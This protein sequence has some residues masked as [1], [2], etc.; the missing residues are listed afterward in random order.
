MNKITLFGV[1]QGVGMRPFIYTLAQKLELVGFVRNTQAALEIILPAHK[2]ESFLNALKKGLPPLA[3]VEKIIISPYDKT[4][5]SNDFRILESKNHP[6]NLLSQIP[7]DLGVCKDCLREI[8]DKNSPYFHYAFNSCAKCGARYSLLNAL[9]YDR[10]NSALKP[11]KLC[12]FCASIYQD[13]T[14]KRFH[15]QGISCKKCGITLNYK[16]FKNDDALLECAKDIQKGKIIALKGL[17]GFALLCDGRNFQT[18]ER[19]RLLKNRPLKPFALMFKDLN[20]A[21][22]H[23]FLNA[24]E[25]ESLNST[26]AP[27]LLARKK[28]NTPL[29]PNIAKNSPFYGVILPYTPL[30]AL[31]L[32]LLDFPIVFTSANFSSL[33]LASDEAEID[34]LSFIF[35]FKLTHNRAIIHRIDDSIAQCI[36][37]AMRPMRLARGFAPLYLTLP[38]RSNDSQKKILALGAEQKGHFSLLDSKTST[39]LLSPFCGDLSV[40]ENEKHFKETLNFFLKTYDFK[41]TI[42][43]CDKHKNYTTTKMAFDFN[44]PL[45]QVQHHHAHFLASVLDALL[46]APHLNHPFIGIIWDGS[47]AYENKIYGA[48]CFVGDFERI[49]EIARF[50]EFLLLGGGKAI[51]EPKRLVLEI[52]LKHQL[53]KLLERVQKHFKEDEL[54]IFQQMHDREIQSTATNSIGRL[55]DIVAFSL[56]LTGTIS[57]EAESG[58]VLENLA[59]QSDEIAF[60]PF[61]IKNSVVCLKEFY[62]AFEK[63]LGILEPERIAKKFFNSLVEIITAL[64]APFKE[65]VVVCS[66]GVFCN[67]LLCEQLAKRLR[68]LKRQYFFHKHFPPNDSSIPIGQALMA[69]F[70]PTIIKKG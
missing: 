27:I 30:H 14:N 59:L 22:Q 29:A 24:L 7:K 5:K 61:K 6:L 17:G 51:K 31:L 35:D 16:R 11:F 52:A 1:V 66:G 32:D 70:N 40:L 46:Q 57:F 49:E 38:K 48:E 44:T 58:Q 67:Q 19:L 64:I 60:Y 42:L 41:P 26:S 63:D 10:E 56:D 39:L 28:P 34:A 3:L 15:I 37:N 8:R 55:F 2:T 25:C 50:E 53:N 18:I 13:P 54:E 23:A 21:K 65:H 47:G 69:Y 68:G 4:L 36:D 20:T 43:T 12:E 9:P 33:P 45:L 62:Q